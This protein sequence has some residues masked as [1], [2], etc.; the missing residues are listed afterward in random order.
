MNVDSDFVQ[1]VED[2]SKPAVLTVNGVEY[3]T[4]PVTDVR[5][6]DPTAKAL[7]V[8]T[9]T[10]IVDYLEKNVD[11]AEKPS[12]MLHVY[13]QNEVQLISKLA[14][15]FRQRECLLFAK[16]E[17]LFGNG[18]QF[19]Q[20]YDCETF[21][22]SL[23]SL[24]I[25]TTDCEKLLSIVGNIKDEAVSTYA[26]DGT[27]QT[28]TA[29][30]GIAL[31]SDV[32]L[33]NPV[34]LAPWRTFREIDQSISPFVLRLKQNQGQKPSCALFESDGGAWKIEAINRIRTWLEERIKDVAIIA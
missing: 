27:T 34:F 13:S 29:K 4:K 2:L 17:T 20:Y 7:C 8:A 25:R 28:V 16:V 19:G 33:P 12:L 23:Q 14:G 18:F 24:F 10:G 3:A 6:A 15:R 11:Q 30:A 22:V 32:N 26:D 21:N 5:T 9:L 31:R 1:A